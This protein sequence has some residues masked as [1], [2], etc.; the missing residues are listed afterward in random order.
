M[1]TELLPVLDDIGRAREHDE[2]NGGF[3]QVAERLEGTVGKLGLRT[4]RHS[5][6]TVRPATCTRR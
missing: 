4:L 5:G 6:R 1:L 2:L 3:K